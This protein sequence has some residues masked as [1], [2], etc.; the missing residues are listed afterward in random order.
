MSTMAQVGTVVRLFLIENEQKQVLAC[1]HFQRPTVAQI[2]KLWDVSEFSARLSI[3][4]VMEQKNSTEHP[5][6]TL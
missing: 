4:R 5:A 2:P 3:K 6:L 1:E